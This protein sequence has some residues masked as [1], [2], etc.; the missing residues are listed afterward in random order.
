MPVS[1]AALGLLAAALSPAQAGAPDAKPCKDCSVLWIVID[2]T[3]ADYVGCFGGDPKTTPTIDG[4]CKEGLSFREAYAQAPATMLSVSSYFSG[5]YRMNTGLDFM[6]WEDQDFHPLSDEVVTLAEALR[7]NGFKVHGYTANPSIS[8]RS[9]Q[10]KGQFNLNFQQGFETWIYAVDD[11]IAVK[12]PQK[13]AELAG[14]GERFF[15]YLHAM[16]P[17]FPNIRRPGFE[18]RQ[19][20]RFPET[21]K[22]AD[23]DFNYT[24][25]NKGEL[26][27]SGLQGEY[28]RALYADNLWYADQN[29]VGPILDK[30]RALGI[31]DKLLIVFSSDHGEALGE[32]HEA[33]LGPKEGT[34]TYWGHSHP[35]LVDPTLHI[36]L[37]FKGPGIPSGVQV[38]DQVAE[39]VDIAPT[40]VNYLGLEQKPEWGWDGAPL[41]GPGAVKSTWSIADQGAGKTQRTAARDLRYTTSLYHSWDKY[42][43]FDHS[44]P[45]MRKRVAATPAHQRL[46]E[47]IKK[48]VE[49]RHPPD[50]TGE[51]AAPDGEFLE[52]LKAL[53]YMED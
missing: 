30:V 4:L 2:T 3:R 31:E 11:D 8:D 19:G 9:H 16:G 14:S 34:Q 50:A 52:Q 22:Q 20:N 10:G 48:Y 21:L 27:A 25:I 53:G 7:D 1:S 12:G 46:Q 32:Q 42:S 29:F 45:G 36:P 44:G 43:Y 41:F 23:Q 6:L 15:L 33:G 18:S 35:T 24:L 51:M 26:D 17:H 37:A 13:L 49:T 40:V 5:R 39:N 38:K 28:L 47:L